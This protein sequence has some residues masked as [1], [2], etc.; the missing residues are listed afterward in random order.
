MIGKK[1]KEKEERNAKIGEINVKLQG[2]AELPKKMD[3]LESKVE[4]QN[5]C[6]QDLETKTMSTAAGKVDIRQTNATI[7]ELRELEKRSKNLIFM[8]VPEA[9]EEEAEKRKDEDTAKINSILW[10]ITNRH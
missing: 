9:T 2:I 6:L 5:K 8:N 7:R 3:S 1:E 10:D 4:A